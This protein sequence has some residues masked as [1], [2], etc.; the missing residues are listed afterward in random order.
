MLAAIVHGAGRKMLE[1]G[2]ARTTINICIH[3]SLDVIF[4]FLYYKRKL[5]ILLF[6]LGLL[7]SYSEMFLVAHT[8]L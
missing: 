1:Y 5:Q 8:V 2:D 6:Y 4:L 3:A 7:V